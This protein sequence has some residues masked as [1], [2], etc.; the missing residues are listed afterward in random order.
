MSKKYYDCIHCG[1]K[2]FPVCPECGGYWTGR[3]NPSHPICNLCNYKLTEE[4]AHEI[5]RTWSIYSEQEKDKKGIVTKESLKSEAIARY[6][7]LNKIL[8]TSL[9]T[10][11]GKDI[12]SLTQAVI[13]AKADVEDFV[14]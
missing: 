7:K 14:E 8:M 10:T 4:E 3:I 13:L 11:N 2:P 9:S 5:R 1:K 6:E 12:L